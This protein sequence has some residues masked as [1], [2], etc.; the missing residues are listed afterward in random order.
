MTP[1]GVGGVEREHTDFGL[2]VV[3]PQVPQHGRE[4]GFV[5]EVPLAVV[6]AHQVAH[7]TSGGGA[8]EERPPP[9]APRPRARP[10]P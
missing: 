6:A 10:G 5:A 9:A 8:D 4:N 7:Q 1:G 2:G 3:T